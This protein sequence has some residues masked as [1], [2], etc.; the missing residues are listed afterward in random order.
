MICER[1]DSFIHRSMVSSEHH[2]FSVCLL[3]PGQSVPLR[4]SSFS[5]P[6]EGSTSPS[7]GDQDGTLAALVSS[8]Q[9]RERIPRVKG[10]RGWSK[11]ATH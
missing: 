11:A 3:P 9:R 6:F 5:A 7:L 2:L 1:R 8:C 4:F 10:F